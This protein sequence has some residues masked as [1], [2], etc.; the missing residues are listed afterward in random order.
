[1][2]TTLHDLLTLPAFAAV[3]VVSGRTHLDQ[4][5]AWVHVSEVPDAARFLTG[6]ELLLSTGVP[7]QGGDDAAQEHYLRSLAAGGAQGLMLELVRHFSEVPAAVLAAARQLDFPLLVA[8][9]EIS[10]ALLTRAA[11]S[12]ILAPVAA[13]AEPSLEP[14]LLALSETGRSTDFIASH[15][16]PLLALP[17]RPR[18]TLLLT[19]DALLA[20]NFNITEAA[21]RLGVRRQ[22]MY[23]RIEQL[24]AMLGD[25][26]DARR[27]LGLRL[28]L[29]LLRGS[30]PGEASRP[31]C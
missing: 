13:P 17:L 11:H 28:S 22:T 2:H 10:F 23:Y 26:E 30:G 15:L 5:V 18:A 6:G 9:Q 19:L 4:P 3:E 29:E 20:V 25:L 14:L 16:G 8:R 7:L 24:R 27:Q 12:R 1:M 21:R 31:P